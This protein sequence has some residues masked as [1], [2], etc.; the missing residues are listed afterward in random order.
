MR[1]TIIFGGYGFIGSHLY[2]KIK[3]NKYRFTSRDQNKYSLNFFSK[4]IKKHNPKNIFFLSGNPSPSISE[5]KHLFDIK[6]NNIK[7][8]NLLEAAKINNFL[9]KIIYGS[10]I[11]VYGSNNKKKIGENELLNPESHYAVSKINAENQCM[12]YANKF[13]LN[14]IVLRLSSVFG[15]GLNRQVIYEIIKKTILNPKKKLFMDGSS[16]D[17]RE[18]LFID[19]LIKILLLIA[20]KKI[21]S[22]IYNIG[23]SRQIYIKNI[24]KYVQKKLKLNYPVIF[25]KKKTS[26]KFSIICTKKIK[27]I[28]KYKIKNNLYNNLNKTIRYCERT[29]KKFD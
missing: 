5:N 12:Y 15:P 13:K 7:I 28:I 29:C 9:G 1:P 16:N 18:F 24:I 21:N 27:R 22:G 10:S 20:N 19:D 17:K 14:I 2:K 3:K 4:L 6:V 8:Q 25:L 26:P 23:T 11:A